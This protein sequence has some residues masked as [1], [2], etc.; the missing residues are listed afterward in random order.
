MTGYE[1]LH[2][3]TAVRNLWLIEAEKLPD[4]NFLAAMPELEFFKLRNMEG[5]LDLAPMR[6]HKRLRKL[7][8][9]GT[10]A[11]ETLSLSC[12]D[13]CDALEILHSIPKVL[14]DDPDELITRFP[15]L[16]CVRGQFECPSGDGGVSVLDRLRQARPEVIITDEYN[17]L[18]SVKW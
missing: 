8:W 9:W 3:F 10:Y 5:M 15:K 7:D 12:L 13:G 18:N 4:L 17:T 1:I 11:Q 2:E 6:N 16:R 14:V